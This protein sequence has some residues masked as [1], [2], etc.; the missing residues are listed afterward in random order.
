MFS[1]DLMKKIRFVAI[2][3]GVICCLTASQSRLLASCSTSVIQYVASGTFSSTPVNGN[4]GL[5]LAGN[6]FSI[7]IYVCESKT[8]TKTGT[9]PQP[10]AIYSPLTTT[11]SVKSSLEPAPNGIN[12][13]TALTLVVPSTG[14]DTIIVQGPVSTKILGNNVTIYIHAIVS[15]LQ[16][17]LTTT[18]P[19]TFSPVAL[20]HVDTLEY[21]L[22]GATCP[23]SNCTTLSIASGHVSATI[24]SGSIALVTK[25]L[26]P[27]GAEVITTHADGTQSV[28]SLHSGPV[29]LGANSAT[30]TL[31][32]Y[33]SG[34]GP[35]AET[36]V[37]IAGREVPVLYA[38]PSG[39]FPELDEVIVEVP[40]SLAGA[41]DV[42]VSLVVDG[43][44]ANS[45]PIHIQ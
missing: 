33:A 9:V 12:G 6:P 24:K 13:D 4:D 45:V 17:T 21:Y 31:H 30:V 8:P 1:P 14:R 36:H 35:A 11:G 18:T 28:R 40:R 7:T 38:G 15:V 41:G 37:Q 3:A 34:V 22:P 19:A 23:G 16:G 20:F 43:Q 10:Y 39:Y 26:H 5:Q 27:E 44:A 32:F 2:A 25:V 29:D 42:D